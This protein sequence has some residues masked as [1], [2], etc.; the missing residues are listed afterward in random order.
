MKKAKKR[1]KAK[2]KMQ[3]LEKGPTWSMARLLRTWSASLKGTGK[4]GRSRYFGPSLADTSHEVREPQGKT[5]I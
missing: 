5:N 4:P 1:I 2:G 3:G